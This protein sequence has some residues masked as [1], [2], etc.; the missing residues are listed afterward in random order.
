MPARGCFRVGLSV[1]MLD[2]LSGTALAQL[3]A[4][5]PNEDG[6]MLQWGVSVG[7]AVIVLLACFINPKR[8]H[9]G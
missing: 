6:G 7:L 9:I 3:P 4:R 2:L 1:I 8:S 5:L